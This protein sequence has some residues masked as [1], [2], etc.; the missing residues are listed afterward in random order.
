[1]DKQTEWIREYCTRTRCGQLVLEGISSEFYLYFDADDGG[2]PGT[3]D[4]FVAAV[5]SKGAGSIRILADATE[6][7]LQRLLFALG[8]VSRLPDHIRRQIYSSTSP[9]R[10]DLEG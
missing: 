8:I 2:R 5:A 3:V 6:R 7:Q 10:R 9:L 4:V 1:M